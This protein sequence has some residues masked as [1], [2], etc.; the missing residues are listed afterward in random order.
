M[1][2]SGGPQ[3]RVRGVHHMMDKLLIKKNTN[4]AGETTTPLQERY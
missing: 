3:Y 2:A 1:G 4:P